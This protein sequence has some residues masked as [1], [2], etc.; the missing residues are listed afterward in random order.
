MS[1]TKNTWVD[2]AVQ[3]ASRYLLSLVSGSTYDITASAGTITAD[4]TPVTAAKMNNLEQGVYDAHL[5]GTAE[6]NVSSYSYASKSFSV[7]T[8]DGAP[9]DVCFNTDGTKMFIIGSANDTVYQYTLSTGWDVSTASYASKSFSV[10]TQES[11]PSGLAFNIDGTKMYVI[12]T[13]SDKVFQ[14]TLSTGWDVSTASYASKYCSTSSQESTGQG[15]AFNTDGTKMYITG[16]SNDTVYQYTL[17]TA[18]DVSTGSYASKSFSVTTQDSDPRGIAFNTDG[19]LMYI[20]GNT[21]DTVYQYRLST[22]WDVSTASY[23]NVS[24]SVSSQESSLQA[25]C[26]GDNASKMYIVGNANDTVYQ[27]TCGDAYVISL[28]TT[29]AT[30]TRAKIK[31]LVGNTGACTLSIDGGL[32]N[33]SIK[34][35]LPSGLVDPSINDMMSNAITSLIYDGTYW[36]IQ[37]N[38]PDGTWEYIASTTVGS[39]G[40]TQVDFSSIP[41]DYKLLKLVFALQND[42]AASDNHI[43]LRCND[44]SG[45]NYIYQ[46]LEAVSTTVSAQTYTPAYI[47]LTYAISRNTSGFSTGEILVS[48]IIS[49]QQ[50]VVKCTYYEPRYAAIRNA[51]GAWT[52]TAALINKISFI[53]SANK[54]GQYSIISLWGCK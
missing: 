1:Y 19:T 28:D 50:K 47:Q 39:G 35:M 10:T 45:A 48:N 31:T 32:N 30:G 5:Y 20:A 49:T 13:S 3:Y 53:A 7:A 23:T 18:W 11:S 8:Q 42:Q 16:N 51:F 15:L 4:G 9:Y 34:K 33:K 36:Q 43:Y 25:I 17:S 40:V 12:G 2:R 26:F 44:D 46:I 54:I 21:N 29:L 24:V 52:N 41:S 37:S 14:Y 6:Y 38:I 27:Y 22:A